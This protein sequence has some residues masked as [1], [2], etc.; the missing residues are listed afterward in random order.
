MIAFGL[1]YTDYRRLAGLRLCLALIALFMLLTAGA[2]RAHANDYSAGTYS[3]SLLAGACTASAGRDTALDFDSVRRLSYACDGR[4]SGQGDW[5]WLK[6][7]PPAARER[8]GDD[9]HLVVNETRFRQVRL[10]VER[11]SG[12]IE[13]LSLAG[14]E[15]Q[16]SWV[17]GNGVR[18]VIPPSDVPVKQMY[19]GVEGLPD[20]SMLNRVELV[21]GSALTSRASQWLL[22][23]GVFIG[24]LIASLLYNLLLLGGVRHRLQLVY[25]TWMIATLGYGLLWSGLAHYLVPGLAGADA[26]R[27]AYFTGVMTLVLSV[28]FFIE[29]FSEGQIPKWLVK[30]Q[31]ILAASLATMGTIATFDQLGLFLIAD[32]LVRVLVVTTQI[33]IAYGVFRAIEREP[34]P[35]KIYALGW[36]CLFIAV[37]LNLLSDYG[38]MLSNVVTDT[39]VFTSTVVQALLLSAAAATRLANIR[40]ERDRAQAESERLRSLAETD[41]LTGVFNRRGLVHRAQ[42]VIGQNMGSTL[43][44]IDVDYFKTIND[45]FGHETGDHVLIRVGQI[46][47]RQC[48]DGQTI[49]RIGGEE[50]AIVLDI[51]HAEEALGFADRL[52]RHLAGTDWSDLIGMGRGVTISIGLAVAQPGFPATFERLFVAADRALY[53]AKRGGRNRVEMASAEDVRRAEA[54][55][56]TVN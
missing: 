45:S 24:A 10:F 36:S 16:S 49:G 55:L 8:A 14:D 38:F 23:G 18:I 52:R 7:S 27:A 34:G 3:V 25:L 22:M 17:H 28:L 48:A 4:R 9:R 56:A 21:S 31:R 2:G 19:L 11:Q 40:R 47:E 41:P 12:E 37:V 30:L 39:G 32:T 43:L 33:M 46:L 29:F 42:A 35:A 51:G 1:S 6:L 13:T 5:F 26:A 50:F 54:R 53:R 20:N 15:F 44:L